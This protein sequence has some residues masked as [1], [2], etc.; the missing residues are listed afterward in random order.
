MISITKDANKKPLVSVCIITYEHGAYIEECIK[1][2]LMQRTSFDVEICIGEDGS[3]DGT[4]EI[5]RQYAVQFP[6]KVRLFLRD[7]TDVTYFYG[8]PSG[9]NNF[10]KTLQECRG[11]YIAL[12]E[13]DDR[14]TDPQKLQKQVDFFISHPEYVACY[15]GFKVVWEGKELKE[16]SF[17][18]P[19]MIRD[20]TM[21]DILKKNPAYR[22]INPEVRQTIVGHTCTAMYRQEI[23]TEYLSHPMTKTVIGG[24][25]LLE[26]LSCMR[27][28]IHVLPDVMSLYIAHNRGINSVYT[29]ENRR[30]GG[31]IFVEIYELLQK[32]LPH[33]YYYEIEHVKA[34]VQ[35]F[36]DMQEQHE[37]M[38]NAAALEKQQ[39]MFAHAT[40]LWKVFSKFY[41]KICLWGSGSHTIKLIESVRKEN[42]RMPACVVDNAAKENQIL[43]VSVVSVDSPIVTTCEA[44]ILSS[45]VYQEEMRRDIS[46]RF[47]LKLPIIDLYEGMATRN[48]AYDVI[49]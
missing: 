40:S 5:C 39:L 41:S 12:C 32:L 6:E 31:A 33:E 7:R 24:D 34:G 16:Q 26:A 9:R 11:Q 17:S 21:H 30:S 49:S 37:K 48:E 25:M 42:L 47:F 4:R 22:R 13:G 1:G 3:S 19:D 29:A 38:R 43:G 14:W 15:H 2:A 23:V 10:L 8:K 20:L 36:Y 45:M 27:G 18:S 44:I 28:K 35:L 46:Q